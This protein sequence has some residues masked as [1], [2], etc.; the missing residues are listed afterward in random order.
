MKLDDIKIILTI[1]GGEDLRVGGGGGGEL[2][3]YLP[4]CMK[5][6]KSVLSRNVTSVLLVSH[7]L[8]T[9]CTAGYSSLSVCMHTF[10]YI[11]VYSEI[12]HC[13]HL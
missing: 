3:P 10:L 9:R 11:H 5:P 13:G 4:P 1:L 8:L 6:C 12:L 7:Q 2:P